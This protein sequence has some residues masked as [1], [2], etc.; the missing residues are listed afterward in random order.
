MPLFYSAIVGNFIGFDW[1]EKLNLAK[2]VTQEGVE[3]SKL[4]V[5]NLAILNSY[6][7]SIIDT[8][9]HSACDGHDMTKVC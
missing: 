5:E 9:F 3:S 2:Y 1:N 4:L 7:E 6:G 8:I